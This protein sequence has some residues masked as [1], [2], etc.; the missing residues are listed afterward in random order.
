MHLLEIL[1]WFCCFV[2]FYTY[3]G[4]GVLLYILVKYVMRWLKPSAQLEQR[5][6]QAW[7]E[8]SFIVAA[9]N[10]EDCIRAK[11]LNTSAL[12][13]P[14]EKLSLIFVTDG[15]R[16]RT[17]EILAEFP[18]IQVHYRPER[19]G[20]TAAINRVMKLVK[21]PITIFSDANTEINSQA[22]QEIVKHYRDEKVGAV[23]GEKRVSNP[24]H[25]QASSA[26]EGLYWKYESTLKKWDAQLSSACGAAGELFSIRTALYK[27]VPSHALLD[28]FLISL[29]VLRE[30]YKIAYEPRAYALETSSA[31]IQ[32]ELKRKIRIS[33]GGIQSILWMKDLL[34]PLRYGLFSWQYFSHRVLRWTLAPLALLVV[35]LVNIVLASEGGLIYTIALSLQI[36]FYLLAM[37]GWV[38]ENSQTQVKAFLI[39]FYFLMMNYSVY[40]G[41]WR[42]LRGNQS[43]LWEKAR[44]A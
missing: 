1:F 35:L 36:L 2:L 13:Y 42:W 25:E 5:V 39:P 40:R 23:A 41:F 32:E 14:Q 6:G 31:S 37:L 28:D 8:V 15:S 12:D 20:K 34:N 44:R 10:E 7:P 17:N 4:Y 22:I 19:A 33:A 24:Q 30:G 26:G 29:K 11:A 27:P 9:Y 38:M 3:I 43:V 16:D 21:T 18:D